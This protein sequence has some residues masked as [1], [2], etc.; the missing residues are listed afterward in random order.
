MSVLLK[1]QW[2][3]VFGPFMLDPARRVLVRGE[4]PLSLTTKAF[5]LL[6]FLLENPDRVVEKE[7]L[8]NAIWPGKVV[9]ESNLSQT[10]FTLRKTLGAIQSGESLIVTAPGRGYRIGVPVR[11]IVRGE[12]TQDARTL[13]P[14]QQLDAANAPES[15][16]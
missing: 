7:E 15:T 16:D 14:F 4:A 10:V 6:L 12:R 1:D 11:T 5:D 13:S 2:V 9:E 8:F 3:Y